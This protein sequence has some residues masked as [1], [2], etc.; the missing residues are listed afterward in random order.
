[1][2]TSWIIFGRPLYSFVRLLRSTLMGSHTRSCT[3]SVRG[4]PRLIPS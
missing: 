1:M 2:I 3:S 4:M